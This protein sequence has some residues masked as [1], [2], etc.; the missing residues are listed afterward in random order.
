MDREEF[1]KWWY[2]E[3]SGC[4]PSDHDDMEGHSQAVSHAAWQASQ[5]ALIERL[6]EPSQELIN[7]LQN[8]IG[9]E[10]YV[11]DILKAIAEHLETG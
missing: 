8:G 7:V 6:K 4:T 3:G 1:G 2:N 10:P 9:S 11:K 5:K